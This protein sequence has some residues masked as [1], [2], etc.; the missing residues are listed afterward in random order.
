MPR[1]LSSW[2]LTL[3]VVA[4]CGVSTTVAR[5]ESGDELAS[6]PYGGLAPEG[7]A[8][9]P[10]DGTFWVP[11]FIDGEVRHFD[12]NLNPLGSF[13]IPFAGAT[14]ATGITYYPPNDTLLLIEPESQQLLEVD[15][16]GAPFPG[17]LD[18]IMQPLPVVNP[19][20]QPVLRGL[21]FYP[22]GNGGLGS[23]F[24]VETVGSLIYEFDLD[25]NI[26]DEFG[27]PD[28]PDGYP[29]LGAGAPGGGIE[30]ILDPGGT[31]VGF[32]LI[33]DNGSGPVIH[34]LDAAGNPTGLSIPLVDTGA[35]TVGG[36]VRVTYVDPVTTTVYDAIYGTSE[37]T[38]SL[39]IVDGELP[40]IAEFLSFECATV[41]D[42]IELNWSVG[43]TYDEIRV[44]RNGTLIATLPG[45]AV[46]YTDAGLTHDVYHYEVMAEEGTLTTQPVTC[47]DVIGT[48]QVLAQADLVD[49]FLPVDMTED[50]TGLLWIT[51]LDNVVWT[52]DKSLGLIT[53]FT[54]PFPEDDDDLTGIAYRASSD[55]LFLYNAF[56]N[57]I[58][59]VDLI[60]TPVGTPFTTAIPVPDPDNPPFVGSLLYDPVSLG[61]A[62]SFLALELE[63]ATVYRLAMDGSVLDSYTHPE[64][65]DDPTPPNS[66]LEHYLLGLSAVP[67]VGNGYEQ[68][69]TGS[70]NLLDRRMTRILRLD[71][72]NGSPQGYQL[73]IEGMLARRV[74]NYFFVHNTTYQGAPVAIGIALRTNNAAI[75]RLNRDVPA[76]LPVDFL[77]CR[78]PDLVDQVE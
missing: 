66:Y 68:F 3:I 2:L 48:G 67:E 12:A 64:E 9:D 38:A 1:L 21:A 5:A 32:D 35:A 7:I 71:A 17:G 54:G 18:L 53:S 47:F 58:Q 24:A 22:A 60:G 49:A 76:V 41:G 6:A 70:G 42:S 77:S 26:L 30:L 23:L 59:E 31:L 72:S 51:D 29:G 78:Q 52:Y 28:D 65:L 69:D 62:G 8:F 27:H 37:S 43:Q 50:A 61:G 44:R 15:K 16:T 10:T 25:G 13:A 55:T 34:R 33:G 19:L 57:T 63:T 39:F 4:S 56:N 20:G 36:I 73:P 14:G 45:T 74:A 40:P 46:S 11:S 75:F